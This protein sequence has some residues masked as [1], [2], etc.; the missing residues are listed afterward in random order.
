MVNFLCL[1]FITIAPPCEDDNGQQNRAILVP[2][3]AAKSSS[4]AKLKGG[5]GKEKVFM[6]AIK[7]FSWYLIVNKNKA[8]CWSKTIW[9]FR[10]KIIQMEKCLRFGFAAM[11]ADT[12]K[13]KKNCIT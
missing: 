11:Y 3:K 10:E 9:Y 4:S 12:L 6:F 8:F 5:R 7:W 2:S 13:W 1:K